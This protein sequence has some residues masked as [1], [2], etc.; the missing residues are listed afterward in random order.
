MAVGGLGEIR[1][2]DVRAESNGHYGVEANNAF[3]G[4]KADVYVRGGAFIA[5]ALGGLGIDSN[6][7][8][9]VLNTDI[10]E[11]PEGAALNAPQ[12]VVVRCT[13]IR[14]NVTG[15]RADSRRLALN[16]V[17]FSG[18]TTDYINTGSTVVTLT[19]RKSP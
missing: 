9:H 19:C 14:N 4:V 15:I 8:I 11:H 16:G 13:A 10:A 2:Q 7:E 18:N 6:R 17:A 5:N 1:I 3:S 12:R